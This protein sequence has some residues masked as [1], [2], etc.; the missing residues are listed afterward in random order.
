LETE[1]EH[2]KEKLIMDCQDFNAI[3]GF[4]LFKPSS[5]RTQKLGIENLSAAFGSLGVN[6]TTNQAKLLLKRYDNDRDGLLTYTDICDIYKPRDLNL[7]QEF[8]RRLPFD[9]KRTG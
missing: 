2:M 5:D 1:L 6:L 9:H 4:K 7:A 3:I 8:E